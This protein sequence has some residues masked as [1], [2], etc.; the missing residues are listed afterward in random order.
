LPIGFGDPI[1]WDDLVPLVD[2]WKIGGYLVD[3]RYADSR[4]NVPVPIE[5][6]D[7]D[8]L[9]HYSY[10]YDGSAVKGDVQPIY[11]NIPT[12]NFFTYDDNNQWNSGAIV[13]VGRNFS[14]KF[15][16]NRSVSCELPSNHNNDG[17]TKFALTEGQ[18]SWEG[19]AVSSQRSLDQ[20]SLNSQPNYLESTN[21]PRQSGG[22]VDP[23]P[24]TTPGSGGIEIVSVSTHSLQPGEQFTPSVT[25]R[26]TS[27][28]LIPSRGTTCM[29]FPKTRTT[30][31]ARG[32]SSPSARR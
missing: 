3:R 8:K 5:G 19:Q 32:P 11:P 15:P 1:G 18:F 9:G 26:I 6:E 14:C 22:P 13:R 4:Y 31:S 30:P 17:S 28:Q 23:P 29:P 10:N 12:G 7:T 16:T 2:S 24:G 20:A 21:T 25:V 27:G